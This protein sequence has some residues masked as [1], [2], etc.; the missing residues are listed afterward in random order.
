[1]PLRGFCSHV[2]STTARKNIS[3]PGKLGRRVIV[4]RVIRVPNEVQD[5]ATGFG[6]ERAPLRQP[7]DGVCSRVASDLDAGGASLQGRR[8]RAG[9]S[10]P[11]D[12]GATRSPQ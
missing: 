1:M 9:R 6:P 10:L 2:H 8:C 11:R 5:P 7:V 3:F 12:E 4:N